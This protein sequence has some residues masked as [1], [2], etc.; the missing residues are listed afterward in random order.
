MNFAE[1]KLYHQIHPL[2]LATDIGVTPIFL[3]FLWRHEIVPA[4]LV[5]F[6]PPIVVSAVMMKW[7]P[8]LEWIKNSALGQY[9]KRY[10]T[11]TNEVIR[12]LTLI[13][14]AYGAW[15]HQIGSGLFT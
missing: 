15:V 4:L 1:K 11:P 6:V 12:F 8:D 7:T 9:L 3:Y 2:K 5:G 10:M 13:P 14:M